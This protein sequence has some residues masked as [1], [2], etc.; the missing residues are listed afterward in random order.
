MVRTR[1][2]RGLSEAPLLI[3]PSILR[4]ILRQGEARSSPALVHHQGAWPRNL[5]VDRVRTQNHRA[6]GAP[7]LSSAQGAEKATKNEK[8]RR[9]RLPD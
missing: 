6:I 3:F 2:P 8:S 9:T 7:C 5:R 1:A 4:G